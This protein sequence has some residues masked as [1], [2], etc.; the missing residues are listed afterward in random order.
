[1]TKKDAKPKSTQ[2]QRNNNPTQLVTLKPPVDFNRERQ[3]I[4]RYSIGSDNPYEITRACLLNMKLSKPTGAANSTPTELL[5]HFSAVRLTKVVIWASPE[6]GQTEPPT[7][8]WMTENSN[9]KSFKIQRGPTQLNKRIF[10]PGRN[11]RV[12]FWSNSTSSSLT[13]GES[14]FKLEHAS[15]TQIDIHFDYVETCGSGSTV[16]VTATGFTASSGTVY[17]PLD[18]MAAGALTIG[19]WDLDPVIN[20]TDCTVT[21]GTTP[22]VFTRTN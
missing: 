11:D 1:M 17:P 8:I 3:G 4:H 9:G 12:G 16:T 19:S 7:F 14:L 15:N 21:D 2:R 22:S 5:P 13:Q 10:T 6:S 18:N 20:L